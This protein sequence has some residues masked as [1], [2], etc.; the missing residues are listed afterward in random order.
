VILKGIK[1][2]G[3]RTR[4]I[5]AFVLFSLFPLTNFSQSA[6]SWSSATVYQIY[7][8]S[9][10]DSDGD[11]VG[12]LSGIVSRLDH[13]REMGFDAV[14]VSPFY[15]S[16]QADFGYDIS[17]YRS[18][19][20]EYGTMQDCER[21][22]DEV[23]ARGMRIIFDLVMNHTSDRHPWF[24]ASASDSTGPLAHRYV[25]R[26]GRGPKGRR[27]PTNWKA[28]I[29]G[30]GWHWHEG[31]GAWYWASFLPFQPDLNYNDPTTRAEML[32]VARFW[33]AKGVDGFRLDIFNAI[34]E[35]SLFRNNPP[36]LRVIPSED[37]PDGF[38]Q[39]ARYNVNQEGSFRF[40]TELRT[41]LD[42]FSTPPRFTVG[43]VFGPPAL[44]R[45]FMRH[46]G[47]NGL[48]S[49]FMFRTL[50]T[51]FSA[52]AWRELITDF[53]HEFTP[54]L[55]PTY[56]LGNHDRRRMMGP[57]KNDVRR[58]KLLITLLYTVRG[59]SYMYYGDELG[60]PKQKIPMRDGLDPLAARYGWIP[61]F[62]IDWSGESLNR[63]ECRTPMLWDTSA[64]A[65]FTDS[66]ATPWLPLAGDPHSMAVS[67]QKPDSTSLMVHCRR[68]IRLR[69]ET[70][71]LH[72]GILTIRT[73]LCTGDLLCYERTIANGRL[74]VLLNFSGKKRMIKAEGEIL[75]STHWNVNQEVLGAFEGRVVRL[76]SN[77]P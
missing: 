39:K 10:Q 71:E 2:E 18:I 8:R 50:G 75:Y 76:T 15:A 16:P 45:G 72:A 65:G 34:A 67:I 17:D 55:Q 40:A 46:N 66:S 6:F 38:F 1:G 43:E 5:L 12:D 60:I 4:G 49:V 13:V 74:L 22:I 64:N 19:A 32:D 7:P 14:W 9:F 26:Q 69:K 77:S 59:Q 31:R 42:S 51:P 44:L 20:P 3:H 24:L 61:Q 29:G 63:D 48:H 53:E 47:L 25:W 52:K 70:P 56:V 73:D 27:Q 33:L 30:S 62:M 54:P 57:L 68:L 36:S 58:A 11:G 23:H 35:D 37:N 28:M 41:L 21:L